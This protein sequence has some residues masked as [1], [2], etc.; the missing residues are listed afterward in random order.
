PYG[1]LGL[2]SRILDAKAL[3][4]ALTMIL[5]E[6][7]PLSLLDVYSDERRKVFQFF[8]DPTST[9]NKL[10]V[11]TNDQDEAHQNNWYFQLMRNATKKVMMEQVK[12]YF[13]FWRTDMKKPTKSL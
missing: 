5:N 11:H 6:S 12:P 1:V 2:N 8:V 3:S 7:K 4:D 10:R 9:H 13:D